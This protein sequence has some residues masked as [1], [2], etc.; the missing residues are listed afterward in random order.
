MKRYYFVAAHDAYEVLLSVDA[1]NREE[2]NRLMEE[3]GWSFEEGGDLVELTEPKIVSTESLE[4][5][6]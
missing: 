1:E 5:L 4:D 2:A 6:I 3:G